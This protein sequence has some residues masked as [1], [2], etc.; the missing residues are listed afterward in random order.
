MTAAQDKAGK[1]LVDDAD[2]AVKRRA[3]DDFKRILDALEN[4]QSADGGRA[5]AKLEMT[6]EEAKDRLVCFAMSSEKGE[7]P[8]LAEP[9]TTLRREREN[10]GEKQEEE[11]ADDEAASTPPPP[12]PPPLPVTSHV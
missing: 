7:G 2:T 8:T 11:D 6:V 12:P 4:Q 10:S 5:G 9:R 1:W 3:N